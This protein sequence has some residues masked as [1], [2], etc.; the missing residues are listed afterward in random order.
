MGNKTSSGSAVDP[1]SG[2]GAE[3]GSGVFLAEDFQRTWRILV[4]AQVPALI[5]R[6]LRTYIIAISLY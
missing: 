1:T 5:R 2:Q 3:T 4:G 6:C